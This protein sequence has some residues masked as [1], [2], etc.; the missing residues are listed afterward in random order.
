MDIKKYTA[1]F[2]DGDIKSIEYNLKELVISMMSSQIVEEEEFDNCIDLSKENVISGKLHIEGVKQIVIDDKVVQEQ[3]M[4]KCQ[5]G[6]VAH[7]D[8][9]EN[10]VFLEIEWFEFLPRPRTVDYNRIVITAT[11]IWWENL[12]DVEVT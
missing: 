12:P 4:K 9:C 2:H 5:S 10:Q 8:I 6:T 7:F 1:W 3:L 11:R